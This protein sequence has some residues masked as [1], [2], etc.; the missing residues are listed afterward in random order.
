MT[1]HTRSATIEQAGVLTSNQWRFANIGNSVVRVHP[2]DGDITI[3][4]SAN[5]TVSVTIGLIDS[6]PADAE[7]CSVDCVALIR[8][9]FA[10]CLA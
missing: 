9:L 4:P 5:R 8:D 6:V 10:D 7:M 1:T 2:V 3:T